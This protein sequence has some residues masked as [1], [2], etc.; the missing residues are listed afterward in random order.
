MNTGGIILRVDDVCRRPGDLPELGTDKDAS[1]FFKWREAAGLAGLPVVYGVVPTWPNETGLDRLRND[2]T[3]HELLAVHGWSHAIR[4]EVTRA[5][6]S[7]A[8]IL[9]NTTVYIPPFNAYSEKTISDW[10]VE[11]GKYF[12]GG[13][14][15]NEHQ[16]GVD[17]KLVRGVIHLPAFKPLYAHAGPL[18]EN[19]QEMLEGSL[20]QYPIVATLHVPWDPNFTLV[21]KFIDLVKPYLVPLASAVNWLKT[22]EEE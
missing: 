15:P 20:P 18:Y 5:Q 22:R 6:M 14:Y 10:A 11:G 1:Y 21:K 12:F 2:L 19:A 4:A 16:H 3:G 13:T 9:L 17:P 8:K 7:K